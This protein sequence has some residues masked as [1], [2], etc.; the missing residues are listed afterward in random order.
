MIVILHQLPDER[1]KSTFPPVACRYTLFSSGVKTTTFRWGPELGWPMP[2]RAGQ[3][4]PGSGEAIRSSARRQAQGLYFV[5]L[6]INHRRSGCFAWER[7]I[8]REI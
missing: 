7:L 4:R 5:L 3:G 8:N 2:G 6:W 1:A